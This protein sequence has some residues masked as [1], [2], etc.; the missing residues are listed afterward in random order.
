MFVFHRIRIAAPWTHFLLIK[1]VTRFINQNQLV[2]AYNG[3][4]HTDAHIH[5]QVGFQLPIRCVHYEHL[6]VHSYPPTVL[7]R[8]H[9]FLFG[10]TKKN[11]PN[12]NRLCNKDRFKNVQ[13]RGFA[14]NVAV[15]DRIHMQLHYFGITIVKT[16]TATANTHWRTREKE[17]DKQQEIK[18]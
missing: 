12:R 10:P 11:Q 17:N 9:S 13:R 8:L 14:C 1:V 4:T 7:N 3:Y 18:G 16:A 5:N 15:W 2:V 6:I